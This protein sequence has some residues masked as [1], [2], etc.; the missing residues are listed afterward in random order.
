MKKEKRQERGRNLTRIMAVIIS[1]QIL[2]TAM[3]L[4]SVWAAS[5]IES[6]ESAAAV[7]MEESEA[8]S[9]SQNQ[10]DV[11]NENAGKEDDKNYES[12]DGESEEEEPKEESKDDETEDDGISNEEIED[13]DA[14]NVEITDDVT[15]ETDSDIAN[16]LISTV[17][18][19]DDDLLDQ[20]MYVL[21][22]AANTDYVLATKNGSIASGTAIVTRKA[23][24]NDVQAWIIR[25]VSGNY[26]YIKNALNGYATDTQRPTITWTSGTS[27]SIQAGWYMTETNE[28]QLFLPV[29]N[30]DGTYTF[31]HKNTGLALDVLNG[32]PGEGTTVQLHK[33]NGTAAQKFYLDN[34]KTHEIFYT[35]TSQT[36]SE[37]L[38]SNTLSILNLNSTSLEQNSLSTAQS[39]KNISFGNG[40]TVSATEA[41][42]NKSNWALAADGTS[43]LPMYKV[44][45][46]AQSYGSENEYVEVT[47]PLAGTYFNGSKT[48]KVGA[49]VHFSNI[50]PANSLSQ[51][52][53]STS[54]PT[55]DGNKYLLIGT[56]LFSG[57]WY[58]NIEAMDM[59]VTFF[60]A[61]TGENLVL[62]DAYM[63]FNSLGN[64]K[65]PENQGTGVDIAVSSTD[66]YGEFVGLKGKKCIGYVSGQLGNGSSGENEAVTNIVSMDLEI[67][68][69][70]AA[71]NENY[72]VESVFVGQS[73]LYP[74][75][76]DQKQAS[77]TDSLGGTNFMRESISLPLSTESESTTF[78]IGSL[79]GEAWNSFSSVP[80]YGNVENPIKS[81]TASSGKVAKYDAQAAVVSKDDGKVTFHI[82]Q[83]VPQIGRE[84]GEALE[85]L[86]VVDEIEE[87]LTIEEA[88]VED[89]L[90]WNVTIEGQKVTFTY[91]GDYREIMDD[92]N[93]SIADAAE[94]ILGKFN[95]RA[96]VNEKAEGTTMVNL[97]H[98][99]WKMKSHD[100]NDNPSNEVR[101]TPVKYEVP[102]LNAGGGGYTIFFV[103]AFIL[104]LCSLGII[105]KKRR[106]PI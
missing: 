39:L 32:V 80:I 30:D 82:E 20:S 69:P 1:F 31:I 43:L 92:G 105:I 27:L 34:L 81:I 86:K 76:S 8:D 36:S 42:S 3:P 41:F 75:T 67:W 49:R 6:K 102:V 45:M 60:D 28:N 19:N 68:A 13:K 24:G 97:A 65:N 22:C 44:T 94:K 66:G 89:D 15:Q 38:G 54:S 74:G 21:K 4:N 100:E 25:K 103:A 63:T 2:F 72:G 52:Y 16:D 40:V 18:E 99:L 29:L 57:F 53:D 62:K 14:E 23:N 77:W 48:I 51:T 46:S 96:A 98:T 11:K 88:W 26:V 47:Y 10:D 64:T 17:A 71:S 93:G 59:K 55:A 83:A 58:N 78:I 101:V 35:E 90:P 9:E 104:L 73:R 87:G 84:T 33:A 61:S 7:F 79:K 50:R 91:T 106:P 95:I 70:Y 5:A 56:N 85:Y 12:G 37:N